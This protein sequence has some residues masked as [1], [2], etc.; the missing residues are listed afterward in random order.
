[1]DREE[2]TDRNWARIC[3]LLTVLWMVVALPSWG[4]QAFHASLWRSDHYRAG[5]A[6]EAGGL[7]P[8]AEV[9]RSSRPDPGLD[10]LLSGF[11]GS[12]QLA[13][14]FRRRPPGRE[15]F[16]LA[17][18]A[19]EL[20]RDLQDPGGSPRGLLGM[21]QSTLRALDAPGRAL[22]RLTGADRASLNP[23]RKRISFTWYV[24]LP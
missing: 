17:A 22:S 10:G 5:A 18:H 1:M 20:L 9:L 15:L 13:S 3:A 7:R 19:E 16:G 14:G 6:P 11:P 23:F 12:E 21:A 8:L 4:Q 24:D 2:R